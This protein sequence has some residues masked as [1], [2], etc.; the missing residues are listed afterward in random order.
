MPGEEAR[1]GIYLVIRMEKDTAWV[2]PYL[3]YQYDF[4]LIYIFLEDLTFLPFGI[5]KIEVIHLNALLQ[6]LLFQVPPAFLLLELLSSLFVPSNV[7]FFAEVS[8]IVINHGLELIRPL[9]IIIIERVSAAG[10][11]RNVLV[12][13]CAE[14]VF[15][16][17]GK[18][19]GMPTLS[20]CWVQHSLK[21]DWA[22]QQILLQ[23][24]PKLLFMHQ[25]Y[26]LLLF[27]D[28]LLVWE[29]HFF[30]L[31]FIDFRCLYHLGLDLG[32]FCFD[33]LRHLL[34]RNT[35]GDLTWCIY[36]NVRNN[37]AL[38]LQFFNP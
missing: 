1:F 10:A 34:L 33:L 27:G 24:Q 21:T 14:E 11:R 7:I 2:C 6:L 30:D 19:E 18:A 17:A 15:L 25:L 16:N 35:L 37:P 8:V 9:A 13:R 22:V 23:Y 38:S 26:V 32:L 28:R 29:Q 31:L 4:L 36:Q 20:R 12:D 5:V 3:Q